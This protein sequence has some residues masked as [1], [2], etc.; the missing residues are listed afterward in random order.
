MLSSRQLRQIFLQRARAYAQIDI[1]LLGKTRFFAAASLTNA[2][3]ARLCG[4]RSSLV[5]P[6]CKELLL[7]LGA[8]LEAYNERLARAALRSQKTGPVLDRSLVVLEQRVAQRWWRSYCAQHSSQAR[9]VERELDDLLNGT[10]PASFFANLWADSR[11][12]NEV[13]SDSRIAARSSLHFA[14][15]GD[16]VRIGYSLVVHLRRRLEQHTIGG[17]SLQRTQAPC[18]VPLHA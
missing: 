3:L 16:R 9:S 15:Q 2:V 18:P 5:S 17:T 11:E 8:T 10:H 1:S 6:Q 4:F 13:L 7:I 12:Y 14:H